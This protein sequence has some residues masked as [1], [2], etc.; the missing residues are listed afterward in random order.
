VSELVPP[1]FTAPIRRVGESAIV[2][3]VFVPDIQVMKMEYIQEHVI[4][5]PV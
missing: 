2:T 3:I 1:T 4:I 5:E